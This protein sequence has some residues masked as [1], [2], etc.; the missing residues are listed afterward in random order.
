[1]KHFGGATIFR[2]LLLTALMGVLP[3]R[4]AAQAARNPNQLAEPQ[5]KGFND[6]QPPEVVLDVLGIRPGF[7]VGEVGA[8]HGRVTVHLAA[9]VGDKGKVR[10]RLHVIR[11]QFTEQPEG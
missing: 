8:G 3:A 7:V 1:M 9:R 5:E 4:G 2:I 10:R 6:L 11:G